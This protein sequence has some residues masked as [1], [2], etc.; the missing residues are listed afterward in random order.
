MTNDPTQRSQLAEATDAYVFGYALIMMELTRRL[1]TNT[2]QPNA[3]Q[4]P[5]NQFCQH[6]TLPTP[7]MKDVVR[8]N[9]DTLY[10]QAWIDLSAGPL[11][12]EVPVMDEGRYWLMQLMDAWSN[13]SEQ[14]PSSIT[15]LTAPNLDP[16]QDVQVY[17]YAL[18]GPGWQG[19]LPDGLQQ[20]AFPTDTVWLIGRIELHDTSDAEVQTVTGYQDQMRLLPLDVWADGGDYTPPAGSYDPTLPTTPPSEAITRL[21]GPEFF[22]ELAALLTHTP[23]DPPDDRTS[24]LLAEL[25][26]HPYDADRLPDA[27]TLDLAKAAGLDAI[28][29]HQGPTPVNGWTFM[30]TGIGTY[31]TDYPQRAYVASIGL[32]ANLPQD[33][34]YPMTGNAATD[35]DGTPLAYTLT[36][37]AGQLP[38]V[39]AFWSLTAYNSASFLVD[40]PEDIYAIGHFATP[41]TGTDGATTLHVQAEAPADPAMQAANWLPIPTSGTF[42]VTLRLYAP[43]TADLLPDWPPALTPVT[44][45]TPEG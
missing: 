16:T 20:V 11:V 29:H 14:S 43:Q 33:A 21:T 39:N 40:N 7:E 18:T 35:G 42:T 6:T 17:S 5:V 12:L 13:T 38:P 44:P 36:F 2:E 24:A 26:L 8:P 31:G 25:G 10:T 41:L 19:E 23:L 27:E 30:T 32:G 37:P 34:L 3:T 15:P 45:V 28:E 4:A 9:L 1:Q 22:D